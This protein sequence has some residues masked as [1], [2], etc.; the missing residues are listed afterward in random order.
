M[1]PRP[2]KRSLKGAKETLT[3]EQQAA[4]LAAARPQTPNDKALAAAQHA[5]QSNVTNE[6]KWEDRLV[7]SKGLAQVTLNKVHRLSVLMQLCRHATAEIDAR[8]EEYLAKLA[9]WPVFLPAPTVTSAFSP[10]AP[11]ARGMD[12]LNATCATAVSSSLYG[13]ATESGV[14]SSVAG[15]PGR[16]GGAAGGARPASKTAGSPDK[17]VKGPPPA[18]AVDAT[19]A[20]AAAIKLQFSQEAIVHDLLMALPNPLTQPAE[21]TAALI[22]LQTTGTSSLLAPGTF[23]GIVNAFVANGVPV[24][25]NVPGAP[26]PESKGRSSARGRRSLP[27]PTSPKGGFAAEASSSFLAAASAMPPAQVAQLLAQAGLGKGAAL[28]EVPVVGP[29]GL[30]C[31]PATLSAD[32][33]LDVVVKMRRAQL[34]ALASYLRACYKT[35]RMGTKERPPV[36]PSTA[37]DFRGELAVASRIAGP[38]TDI[39]SLTT[40]MT[41]AAMGAPQ[42]QVPS[43]VESIR[44]AAL[45]TAAS[46]DGF[47]W[48]DAA[49]SSPTGATAPTTKDEKGS[50]R[51]GASAADAKSGSP[52][53]AKRIEKVVAAAAPTSPALTQ[54]LASVEGK[55]SGGGKG[56]AAAPPASP[57]PAVVDSAIQHLFML[58]PDFRNGSVVDLNGSGAVGGFGALGDTLSGDFQTVHPH[59]TTLQQESSLGP[60]P[61]K[62]G[63]A[64]NSKRAVALPPKPPA[65][66]APVA[67]ELAATPDL[68]SSGNDASRGSLLETIMSAKDVSALLAQSFHFFALPCPKGVDPQIMNQISSW[69]SQRMRLEAC[70]KALEEEK[71]PLLNRV[72]V[73][74]DIH[75]LGSYSMWAAKRELSVAKQAEMQLLKKR[76]QEEREYLAI[77]STMAAADKS[78]VESSPTGKAAKGAPA[79]R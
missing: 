72:E 76:I 42:F 22:E 54:F 71:A 18:A 26:S 23:S 63:T 60:L 53:P 73:A 49:H 13:A 45:A 43:A 48:H 55:S 69:R 8:V 64:P 50:K 1:P 46:V 10:Q 33:S 2:A 47:E 36:R 29:T 62:P 17:K 66:A 4:A 78:A 20:M 27:M 61:K 58:T 19:E 39:A 35:P 40:A 14:P 70:L 25:G 3:L 59:N 37:A 51:G 67:P 16:K 30:I 77:Q 21:F 12:Q 9:N 15:A 44:S 52:S 11:H 68:A 32:P 28:T 34:G 56:K 7:C 65:V 38:Y 75:V 6:T 5:I 31:T 24:P 41:S 79:R 74:S 57:D